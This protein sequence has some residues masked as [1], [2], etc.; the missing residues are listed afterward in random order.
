[1][2]IA[3]PTLGGESLIT[4]EVIVIIVRPEVEDGLDYSLMLDAADGKYFTFS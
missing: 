2:D 3:D 4:Q 1:V